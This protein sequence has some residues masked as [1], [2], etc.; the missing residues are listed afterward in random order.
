MNVK[1]NR[2]G[3]LN[4]VDV[5]ILLFIA[6]IVMV[7]GYLMFFSD[8]NLLDGMSANNNTKT[9]AYTFEVA[10]VHEDLLLDKTKLPVEKGDVLYHSTKKFSLGEVVYVGDK[11]TYMILNDEGTELVPSSDKSSF[12]LKVEAQ[13]VYDDG[14][15][16][17]NDHIVR[18]G[19]EM[20]FTTPYFTGTCKCVAVEEVKDVE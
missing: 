19:E 1:S 12:I 10:P 18:I 6:T 16:Y 2:R 14:V 8:S 15:Y 3:K 13:A 17:V 20:A 9:V 4:I 11:K 7:V 5:L